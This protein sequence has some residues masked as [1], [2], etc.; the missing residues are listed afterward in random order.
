MEGKDGSGRALR[1]GDG[2][3]KIETKH[4]EREGEKYGTFITIAA[5]TDIVSKNA[6]ICGDFADECPCPFGICP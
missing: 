3:D 2:H 5:K 1:P 6:A 4:Q